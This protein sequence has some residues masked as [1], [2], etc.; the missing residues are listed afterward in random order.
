MG[1]LGDGVGFTF[2]AGMRV[3]EVGL[4]AVDADGGVLD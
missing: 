1:V 2:H 3:G 4:G